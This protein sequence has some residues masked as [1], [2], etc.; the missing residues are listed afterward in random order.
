MDTSQSRTLQENGF[1]N[2]ILLWKNILEEI[3]KEMNKSITLMEKEMT[4]D[5]TIL[6]SLLGQVIQE[7][8]INKQ[9][10]QASGLNANVML[11]E[12]TLKSV[13]IKSR[14]LNII[15]VQENVFGIT[16]FKEKYL[17]EKEKNLHPNASPIIV[18]RK[19][20][21]E[22]NVALNV[23]KWGTGGINIDECRIEFDLDNEDT[24]QIKGGHKTSY[25]GGELI[26][27]YG[28]EN[29]ENRL[30][31]RF[32]ANII[33]ECTCDELIEGKDPSPK[34][35]IRKEDGFNKNDYGKGIGQ[36]SGT[37]SKNYGG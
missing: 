25:I 9:E 12:N 23:L 33:L 22:K 10:F 11:V 20:L 36:I 13:L 6:N 28:I 1:L 35:Y 8:I 14:L 31:G 29:Q 18:A 27:N 4:T 7:N 15:S 21:S 16:Q 3:S 5:L 19:P 24:R 17:Q 26:K 37:E 2:T 32:P 34:T 30:N